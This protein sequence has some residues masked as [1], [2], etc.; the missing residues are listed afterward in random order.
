MRMAPRGPGHAVAPPGAVTWKAS[1]G[2]STYEV[3]LIPTTLQIPFSRMA[4]V[5]RAPRAGHEVIK[6]RYGFH[7][8]SR[9]ATRQDATT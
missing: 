5:Y 4:W 8:G 1:L 3:E 6:D 2:T 7:A 9:G